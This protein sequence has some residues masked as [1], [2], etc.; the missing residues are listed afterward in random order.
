[1]TSIAHRG[2]RPSPRGR[3]FFVA[4]GADRRQVVGPRMPSLKRSTSGVGLGRRAPSD[5]QQGVAF[6]GQLPVG[7]GARVRGE[8]SDRLLQ[9]LCSQRSAGFL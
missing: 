8:G 7:M 4:R 6:F 3:F 1:M 2:D 5:H 9:P